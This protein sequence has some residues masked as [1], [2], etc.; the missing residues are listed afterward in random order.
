MGQVCSHL[1]VIGLTWARSTKKG[2]TLLE[3]SCLGEIELSWARLSSLEQDSLVASGL[4]EF[5]RAL[6]SVG[7]FQ[8]SLFSFVYSPLAQSYP[9]FP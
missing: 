7:T 9:F 2:P 1:G 3:Q 8:L 6:V 5:G 4:G